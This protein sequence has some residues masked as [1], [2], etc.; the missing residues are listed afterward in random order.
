MR[1]FAS[2]F[3]TEDE[4]WELEDRSEIKYEYFNGE[5]FAMSGGSPEHAVLGLNAGAALLAQL[6]G[7]PCRVAGS[8]QRVKVEATG[9]ITYP[10]AV[11]YCRPWRFDERNKDTLL[12]PT[13]IVEVLSPSTLN[14][15]KGAKFDNYKQMESLRDYLLISQDK[16][17]VE[18]YHRLDNGDWLLHTA[19]G[20]DAMIHIE[21][22]DCALALAELYDGIEPDNEPYPLHEQQSY[23]Q[24]N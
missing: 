18:H 20:L 17:Q 13:L 11:G 3:I 15:D 9:L 23:E 10:D 1:A 8:D 2:Q 14:Y 6:R 5:I 21:E 19:A 4:Y 16:V 7:K 24:Q 22:L 12:T